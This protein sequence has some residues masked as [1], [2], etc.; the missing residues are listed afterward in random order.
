MVFIELGI[1]WAII[2][3]LGF[4]IASRQN[5]TYLIVSFIIGLFLGTSIAYIVTPNVGLFYS[6]TWFYLFSA[7]VIPAGVS[8]L[9]YSENSSDYSISPLTFT[10][11]FLFIW[12]GFYFC[13][14]AEMLHAM[15]Y[16]NL[17]KVTSEKQFNPHSVLLDQSQ[18]RFVDQTL[19]TRASNELLGKQMGIGSRYNIG[20]MHIQKVNNKLRW[21]ASFE[22]KSIFRW[23]HDSTVPG[24]VEVSASAYNDSKLVDNKTITIGTD[25]FYFSDYLPRYL[26]EHGYDDK[27]LTDYTLELDEQGNPYWVVSIVAPKIGFSG[28]V[29]TGVIL[30]NAKTKSIKEYNLKNIPSWVDRVQPEWVVDS[31]ISY[32]GEYVHGWKNNNSILG[33]QNDVVVPT[34]GSSLVFTKNDKAAWYTGL[35]SAAGGNRN[36]T[37]QGTMGF[38][39]IDSRTGQATFYHRSGIT[40][41]AAK[42]AIEGR[43]QEY[44]YYSSTP[45]PYDV[46]GV[47]TFISILKDNS[48]NMQGIGMVDYNDRTKV[49]YGQNLDIAM[50]RYLSVLATNDTDGGLDKNLN[51]IDVKG[52]IYRLSVVNSDN[53]TLLYFMLH[54][55]QFKHKYFTASADSNPEVLFTHSG[56]NVDI[57]ATDLNNGKINV[58]KFKNLTIE[59]QQ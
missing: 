27:Y 9:M 46:N 29:T 11:L 51:L 47:S 23:I 16:H 39:L 12:I 36:N 37:Q 55:N 20:T 1:V 42:K 13:S 41:Q 40:E 10:T 53:R 52:S 5:T 48:G 18:A 15:R 31:L 28:F 54:G 58:V 45:I 38:I 3:A 44:K 25:G 14:S 43:V 57:K 34:P 6:G 7:M 50:R 33:N 21:V 35:Q 24:Y 30:V 49:A 32:W 59:K 19:A 22:N 2:F 26:Y 8:I 56:D 17:L 4:F